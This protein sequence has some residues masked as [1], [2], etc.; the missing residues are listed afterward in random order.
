MKYKKDSIE[1]LLRE[2]IIVNHNQPRQIFDIKSIKELSQ[3][4]KNQGVL[5]PIIVSPNQDDTYSLISGERRLRAC[6]LINLNLIP[7]I[8]KEL[9]EKDKDEISLIE[10]IQREDLNIID[11][12]R[13]YQKLME[14]YN[15]TQQELS[16]Q[17]SKKRSTIANIIRLL[18]LPKE[19]QEALQKSQIT[20]GHAK[21]L[22][23]L[24]SKVVLQY[25]VFQTILQKNLTVSQTQSLIKLELQEAT[26]KYEQIELDLREKED[27][28]IY[29]LGTKVGIKGNQDKGIIEIKYFSQ[30]DLE[31]I[32]KLLE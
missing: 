21:V 15:L 24:N 3:S 26:K 2:K 1:Y 7:A 27:K 6:E 20:L 31:R 16:N 30:D 12:A 8:I 13:A 19:M 29:S 14:K 23:S 32:I 22:L 28:L 18:Q 5:Q 9:S 11:E 4:I 10:N 25:R 17:L